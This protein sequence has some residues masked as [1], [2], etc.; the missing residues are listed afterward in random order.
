MLSIAMRV[1]RNAAAG[2]QRAMA[3]TGI[4]LY[5]PNGLM[6]HPLYSGSLGEM[7]GGI[8]SLSV[9]VSSIKK[10]NRV[11]RRMAMGTPKSPSARRI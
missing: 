10:S 6:S 1:K 5:M 3:H 9:Y 11:I 8:V 4:G 7:P 2:K